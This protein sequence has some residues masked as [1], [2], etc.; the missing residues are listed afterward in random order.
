MAELRINPGTNPNIDPADVDRAFEKCGEMV[1]DCKTLNEWVK[2]TMV[3]VI[4][5]ISFE[6]RNPTMEFINALK[7]KLGTAGYDNHADF[8]YKSKDSGDAA[9][10]ADPANPAD[11]Q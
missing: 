1:K 10:A 4:E 7:R 2:K 6:R 9:Q 3:E 8:Y 5:P 11:K